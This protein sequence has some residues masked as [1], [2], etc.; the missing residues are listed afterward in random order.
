MPPEAAREFKKTSRERERQKPA[1]CLRVRRFQ[2]FIANLICLCAT[3][4][5]AA[6]AAKAVTATATDGSGRLHWRP[7]QRRPPSVLK[8]SA[9][10]AKNYF[11]FGGCHDG[12]GHVRG[13]GRPRGAPR[14]PARRARRLRRPKQPRRLRQRPPTRARDFYSSSLAAS[15]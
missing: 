5:V 6:V 1:I 13:W 2:V 3:S 4:A 15:T 8:S 7:E 9:G 11:C 10:G 14:G 12:D